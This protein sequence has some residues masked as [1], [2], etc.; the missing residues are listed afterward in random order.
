MIKKTPVQSLLLVIFTLLSAN[1]Y[2]NT[3]WQQ[4]VPSIC[5]IKMLGQSGKIVF[6]MGDTQSI[7]GNRFNLKSNTSIKQLPG[8]NQNGGYL[9]LV[10]KSKSDNL[11]DIHDDDIILQVKGRRGSHT[12][13]LTAWQRP[14]GILLPVGTYESWIIIDREKDTISAG[15]AEI[16]ASLTLNC[17]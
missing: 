4:K 14:P 17:E 3:E 10:L 16:S 15:E 11:A 5:N 7:N 13:T 8:T 9:R 2:A 12:D 6:G 1:I